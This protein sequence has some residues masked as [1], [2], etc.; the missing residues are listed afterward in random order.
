M[1]ETISKPQGLPEDVPQAVDGVPVRRDFIA[2]GVAEQVLVK[3]VNWLG[4]LVISLPA[5]RAVRAAFPTSTL[6]VIVKRELAGFFSGMKWVD[7]VIPYTIGRGLRGLADR[8]EIIGHIRRRRFD[9][10]ILFPNSFESALWVRLGRVP[11]RAGFITDHRGRLLTDGAMPPGDALSG[12]Q[13]GYWLAMIR[14]TLGITP[15][16]GVE[17]VKLEIASRHLEKMRTWLEGNRTRR[18]LPLIAIAPAAAYGPA[19]EWPKERFAV[20]IDMLGQRGAECVLVGAPAERDL[21]EQVAA[22]ARSKPIVAAGRTTIGELIAILSLCHG[23]AGNDSGAMHLAAALGIPTVGIFGS[24]DPE[25][26]GPHGPR[27]GV[28]Y[29]RLE[30]SPCLERTCRFGHYNCLGEIMPN[31]IAQE[32]TRLGAFR[33][34]AQ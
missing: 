10:A 6:T 27:T 24:T 18:G 34:A 19:K 15:P 5:L 12:H 31:E 30:C 29:H 9:I 25:R 32:L 22:A 14:D 7:E 1:D 17:D 13:R 21:C 11:R 20:L 26:T 8:R 28:I 16:A 3:E 23:F 2:L 33:P 4:D